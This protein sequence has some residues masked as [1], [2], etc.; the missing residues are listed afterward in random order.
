MISKSI[1]MGMIVGAVSVITL[2]G[3]FQI[4]LFRSGLESNA[5]GVLYIDCRAAQFA[6]LNWNL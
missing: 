6:G 5:T 2:V 4:Q 1:L 3:Q